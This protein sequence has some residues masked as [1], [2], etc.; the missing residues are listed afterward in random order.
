MNGGGKI[1]PLRVGQ[2]GGSRTPL[3]MVFWGDRM[4]ATEREQINCDCQGTLPELAAQAISMFNARDYY[5]QHDGLELLPNG[6]R[7]CAEMTMA[8][9]IGA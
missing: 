8:S 1:T 9:I 7:V 6:G 3:P 4:D 5:K 2:E